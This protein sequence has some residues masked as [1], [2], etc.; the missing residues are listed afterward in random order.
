MHTSMPIYR[1][2]C[3]ENDMSERNRSLLGIVLHCV[4][5]ILWI[6]FAI[7][8]RKGHPQAVLPIIISLITMFRLTNM[9]PNSKEQPILAALNIIAGGIAALCGTFSDNLAI[10]LIMFVSNIVAIVRKDDNK[11]YIRIWLAYIIMCEIA[12]I[13]VLM[14]KLHLNSRTYSALIQSV[15]M[16]IAFV[17]IIVI[18]AAACGK[19]SKKTAAVINVIF[20]SIVALLTVGGV[21]YLQLRE[22]DYQ[23]QALDMSQTD[24]GKC[25]IGSVL[26]NG[27]VVTFDSASQGTDGNLIME[28]NRYSENQIFIYS[29]AED[30][31]YTFRLESTG[32]M[33]EIQEIGEK[34]RSN[35]KL[36]ESNGDR[37][38]KWLVIDQTDGSYSITSMYNIFRL[39]FDLTDTADG[40]N[41]MVN[42]ENDN[43]SQQFKLYEVE[44]N[45]LLAGY[46][47]DTSGIPVLKVFM[48][49]ICCVIAL[50]V[51]VP[52]G[53]VVRKRI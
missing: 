37:S 2:I 14:G 5:A 47:A 3:K 26:L 32:Q 36:G 31:A 15:I 12:G 7:T 11:I 13:F 9:Q 1:R 50:A 29:K 53:G 30:G 24:E 8:C 34:N 46:I 51:V 28:R 18:T 23:P 41:L 35:V 17:I 6:L 40:V 43:I 20:L 49:L 39:D 19:A 48:S 22:S 33:M 42:E 4:D 16:D 52:V 25:V 27:Q 45:E 21:G 38:Q 44:D 10:L